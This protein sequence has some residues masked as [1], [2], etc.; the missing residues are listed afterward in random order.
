MQGYSS[1]GG[2]STELGGV[3]EN[4]KAWCEPIR[5]VFIKKATSGVSVARSFQIDEQVL[6][7]IE[8]LRAVKRLHERLQRAVSFR[9]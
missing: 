7:T 1:R 3:E 5:S 4:Q 6:Q 8:L 9:N 2:V